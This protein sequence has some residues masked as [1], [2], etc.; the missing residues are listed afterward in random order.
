MRK[1]VPP[2]FTVLTDSGVP[3]MAAMPRTTEISI[4]NSVSLPQWYA[5][6]PVRVARKPLSLWD[7]S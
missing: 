4:T 1:P 2:R 7:T 5:A 3:T 6:D